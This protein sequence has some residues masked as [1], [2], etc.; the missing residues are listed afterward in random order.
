MT[1]VT[2]ELLSNKVINTSNARVFVSRWIH[3]KTNKHEF[4]RSHLRRSRSA[5][6]SN[7]TNQF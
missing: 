6:S 3:F 7:Q 1:I 5:M 2:N 4:W